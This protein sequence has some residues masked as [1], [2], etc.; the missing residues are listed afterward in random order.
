[1]GQTWFIS[2]LFFMK[3]RPQKWQVPVFLCQYRLIVKEFSCDC[4]VQMLQ[5][6][7]IKISAQFVIGRAE[8]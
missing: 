8:V 1:M 3:L 4:K 7:L 2:C 5:K 6:Y